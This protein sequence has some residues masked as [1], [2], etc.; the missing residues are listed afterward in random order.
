MLLKTTTKNPCFGK[1][2]QKKANLLWK[3]GP[4]RQ[5]ERR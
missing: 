2:T 1:T 5:R 4:V 3:T